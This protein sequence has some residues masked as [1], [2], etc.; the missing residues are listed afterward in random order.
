MIG[1]KVEDILKTFVDFFDLT[2]T[3]KV[4]VQI[5]VVDDVYVVTFRVEV[6]P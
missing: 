6:E 5:E 4:T 1:D 3:K 2:A